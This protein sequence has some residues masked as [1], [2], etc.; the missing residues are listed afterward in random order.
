MYVTFGKRWFDVSMSVLLMTVL[1]VPILVIVV[2][3]LVRLQFPIFFIQKRVG[4]NGQ[5][6]DL[7]KFRTLK[8]GEG[9]E[10][11]SRRFLWGDL[12]RFLSLDELPQL[13]NVLKGD[14]SLIGPR[15]LPVEYLTLY[16]VE[17][18][19]R[20][21]VR[22]GITGWA[23]VNGRHSISWQ[24]KFELDN[25]Y[26]NHVSFRLDMLILFKTLV[27]L[28][29]FRKDKSLAEEKFMGN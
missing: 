15:P 4:W 20:H 22:P 11:N 28:L 5:V 13:W 21:Q 26:V 25:Y 1:S 2:L 8:N 7:Y 9:A 19:K 23:Q 16:S 18:F 17:Q 10:V 12:L 3:Y 6:F 24:S 29:S 14:M 27:L